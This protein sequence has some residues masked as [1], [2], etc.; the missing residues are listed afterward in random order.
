[1]NAECGLVFAGEGCKRLGGVYVAELAFGGS[2]VGPLKGKVNIC[3][4]PCCR[5]LDGSA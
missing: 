4:Q 5:R 1:M 3:L 2:H